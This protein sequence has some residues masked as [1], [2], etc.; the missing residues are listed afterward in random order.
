[1]S[2]ISPTVDASSAA[3]EEESLVT[4]HAVAAAGPAGEPT[5]ASG[6]AAPEGTRDA[7]SSMESDTPWSFGVAASLRRT[8]LNRAMT[9]S[10]LRGAVANRGEDSNPCPFNPRSNLATLGRAGSSG[11]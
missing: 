5:N 1:M 3:A 9:D 7:G 4:E 6:S 11:F 8:S 10:L 2:T